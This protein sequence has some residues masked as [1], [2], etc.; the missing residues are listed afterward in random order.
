MKHLKLFEEFISEGKQVGLLYHY[1]SFNSGIKILE[2]KKLISSPTAD[3]TLTNPVFG[4]SF[5]RDKRFHNSNQMDR[6]VGFTK[7]STGQRPQV[8]FTLDGNKISNNYKIEPYSQGG[9]FAKNRK[10]YE[11]EE[12]IVSNNNFSI[13]LMNYLTSI[14][15]LVEYKKAENKYDFFAEIQYDEYMPLRAEIINFAEKNNITI[16][17]IVNKNGDPWADKEEKLF[18]TKLMDWFKK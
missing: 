5:T 2:S 11:A 10:G 18:I 8:R 16:N 14:D 4:I 6:A 9:S 1:T 15:L 17:L 13:P 7:T 12:R 3:G